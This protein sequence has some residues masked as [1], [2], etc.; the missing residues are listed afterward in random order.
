MLSRITVLDIAFQAD[1]EKVLAAEVERLCELSK[2][3]D[4]NLVRNHIRNAKVKGLSIVNERDKVKLN[5]N[6]IA[7]NLHFQTVCVCVLGKH[8]WGCD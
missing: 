4:L 6:E 5:M 3:G 7:S 2:I 1:T 8:E